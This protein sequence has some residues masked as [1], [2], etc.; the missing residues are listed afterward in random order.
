MEAFDAIREDIGNSYAVTYYPAPNPNEGFRKI[1]IE[2]VTRYREEISRAC[3]ARI[4]AAQLLTTRR[5]RGASGGA[6][7]A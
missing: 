4:S 1:N 5:H 3:A 7:R 6:P 2:I